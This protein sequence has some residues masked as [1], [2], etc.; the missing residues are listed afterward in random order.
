MR[1][2]IASI[3]LALLI[4]CGPTPEPDK[5]ALAAEQYRGHWLVLNY[6]AVWCKP[7][8]EEIPELNQLSR[9]LASRV[10]VV[11]INYDGATGPELADAVAVMGIEF[12]VADQDLATQLKIQRPAVLPTTFV[13]NPQGTLVHTLIGPQSYDSLSQLVNL[14]VAEE[15]HY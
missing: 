10:A 6:W 11:G 5:Q 7:C 15:S 4:S 8:R 3:S 2:L 13:F 14:P 9:K 12:V 1:Y